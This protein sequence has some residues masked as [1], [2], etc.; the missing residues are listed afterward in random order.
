MGISL[1]CALVCKC[2]STCIYKKTRKKKKK[3]KQSFCLV[4]LAI[5]VLNLRT[6]NG[7]IGF[8]EYFIT[9]S[10]KDCD[11]QEGLADEFSIV[12]LLPVNMD[13]KLMEFTIQIDYFLC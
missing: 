13:W 2:P 5:C 11:K 3:K 9:N 10:L 1:F 7:C 12:I 6:G 8:H 4:H